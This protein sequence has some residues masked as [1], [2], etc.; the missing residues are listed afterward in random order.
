MFSACIPIEGDLEAVREKALNSSG[1]IYTV[2]FINPD[3]GSVV[4]SKKVKSG[5]MVPV[6]TD[7]EKNNYVFGGWYKEEELINPWRFKYD[8][9]TGDLALYAR[10][11]PENTTFSVKFI[12][13]NVTV[14]SYMVTVGQLAA[15]PLISKTGYRS[16]GWYTEEE[17][18]HEWD[19][20]DSVLDELNLYI[21]WIINQHEV[22]FASNGGTPVPGAVTVEYGA[23]I[24]DPGTVTKADHTFIGWYKD[25]DCNEPWDFNND[26]VLKDI[27]LYAKWGNYVTVTGNSLAAKLDWLDSQAKANMVYH[28]EVST[29]ESLDATILSYSPRTNITIILK[30]INSSRI[31]DLS[32]TGSLFTVESG[33]TLVLDNNITLKGHNSNTDALVT[34][35]NGG[36]LIMNTGSKI[37]GNEISR[38]TVIYGGG[39]LVDGGVF[40]MNGGEISDNVITCSVSS[41]TGG[42]GVRV[43]NSGTFSIHGGTITRNRVIG[44]SNTAEGSGGGGVF[45]NGNFTMDGGTITNNYVTCTVAGFRTTGGGGVYVYNGNLVMNDGTIENNYIT[46]SGSIAGANSTPFSGGGGIYVYNGDFFMYEGT[47]AGNTI[48]SE[49][50]SNACRGGG[51]NVSG[52][53]SRR[54]NFTME[55]GIISNNKIISTTTTIGTNN[56]AMGGGV[57]MF[58]GKFTMLAGKISGNSIK[59]R[60]NM[61]INGQTEGAGKGGGVCILNS[62]YSEMNGGEISSN[63]SGYGGG[64]YLYGGILTMNDGEIHS[65]TAYRIDSMIT[66]FG[67]GVYVDGEAGFVKNNNGIIRGYNIDDPKSNIIQYGS[68]INGQGYAITLVKY[69]AVAERYFIWRNNTAGIGVTL[70]SGNLLG[71]DY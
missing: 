16:D 65:N 20:N 40:T 18:I 11:I 57:Y 22:T 44:G 32:G 68:S 13:E 51:V 34:V 69:N 59:G 21:K 64:I 54:C 45:V 61:Q 66:N 1:Q 25:E 30:G 19:F 60:S 67:G 46:S 7:P 70:N 49:S 38:S 48:S 58:Y 24:D 9:V 33:V 2:L 71:W 8:T 37:T 41:S 27:T 6:I 47:I 43:M 12:S 28:I 5:E 55:G 35:S 4:D 50:A 56:L 36:A 26:T 31:I 52:S 15:A 39:V 14:S 62:D 23:K 10:W 53:T 3:D 17:F 29:G 63:D 42:G